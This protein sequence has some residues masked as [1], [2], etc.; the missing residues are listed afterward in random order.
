MNV[1]VLQ[2]SNPLRDKRRKQ[3]SSSVFG[4]FFASKVAFIAFPR[5][6]FPAALNTGGCRRSVANNAIKLP[7]CAR[8]DRK[9]Q[10]YPWNQMWMEEDLI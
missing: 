8:E 9:S 1:K 7:P 6:I 5:L 10:D 3:T 2:V 4:V